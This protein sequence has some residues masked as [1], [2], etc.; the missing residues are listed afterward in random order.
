MWP[1]YG[2]KSKI[3]D[4]YPSPKYGKIIEP[5]AGS[6]RYSLR[7]FDREILLV[8]KYPV[9]VDVWKYLQSASEKDILSLPDIED[10]QNIRE[11]N[12]DRGAEI[13]IGFCINGGSSQP[14]VKATPK[15]RYKLEDR[16]SGYRELN[17]N[18]WNRDKKRIARDLYKIRHWEIRLGS[19]EDLENESAT[20]FIDPPYQKGGEYYRVNNKQIDYSHL[21]DWSRSRLGQVIVCENTAADWLPFYPMRQM[22]GQLHKTVEAIWSNLPHDFQSRQES[23]F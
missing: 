3:V 14:K 18:S 9:I 16:S 1:Y 10:G 12:L 4:L 15:K 5:F 7:Y 11:L 13:L 23:L 20:W 2:S 22:S 19:Y 17:F 8:D 6:A 21:A